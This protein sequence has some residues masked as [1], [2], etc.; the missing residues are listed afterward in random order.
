MAAF[1]TK[2]DYFDLTSSSLSCITSND[3]K[4]AEVAEATSEDGTIVAY[5]VFGEKIAPSNEYQM[6]GNLSCADGD[7]KLGNVSTVDGMK[8]CLGSFSI[9]TSA[10][11]AP[12]INASGEQVETNAT[13]YCMYSLP[14]FSLSKKHHAQILFDAFSYNKESGGNSTG[15]HLQSASYEATCSITK[16]EKDGECLTHDV[17]QAKI[18]CAVEFMQTGLT[19]PEI[20]AGEGWVVTAPLACS[21]PDSNWP[22]WSAT[23]TKYLV[24]DAD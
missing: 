21:N 14:E 9:G 18:E 8:I 3:G 11:S 22:T 12:T 17:V 10:G 23:L 15:V 19:P 1:I 6:A 13:A 2:K 4:S 5:N 24:K 16:G 20:T 7:I